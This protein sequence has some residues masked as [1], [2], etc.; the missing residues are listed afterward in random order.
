MVQGQEHGD[1]EYLIMEGDGF[2]QRYKA[3]MLCPM[4]KTLKP[5]RDSSATGRSTAM[6]HTCGRTDSGVLCG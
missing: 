4:P 6:V 5:S 1:G 3:R 2:G